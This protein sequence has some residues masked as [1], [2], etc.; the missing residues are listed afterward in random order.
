M[1]IGSE[2]GDIDIKKWA[3]SIWSAGSHDETK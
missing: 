1:K 3:E 2:N